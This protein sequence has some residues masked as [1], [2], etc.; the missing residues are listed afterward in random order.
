M[1]LANGLFFFSC[2]ER[3]EQKTIAMQPLELSPEDPQII[4]ESCVVFFGL[5][6]ADFDSLS[7][8]LSEENNG[9]SEVLSDFNYYSGRISPRLKQLGISVKFETSKEVWL[10]IAEGQTEKIIFDPKDAYG[11]LLFAKGDIP[12]LLTKFSPDYFTMAKIISE[13]FHV[14]IE[15]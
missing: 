11:M 2:K 7:A 13:Y 1:L 10:Q 5:T 14:K 12:K 6:Q 15:E 3:R 4:K 9:L 8:K